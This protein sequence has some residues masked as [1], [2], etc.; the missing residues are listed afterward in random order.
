MV[1]TTGWAPDSVLGATVKVIELSDH[2][3]VVAGAPPTLSVPAAA[4]KLTP[5]RV[6][7]RAVAVSLRRTNGWSTVYSCG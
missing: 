7:V 1:T 5:W 6:T 2:D 3:D 4:P